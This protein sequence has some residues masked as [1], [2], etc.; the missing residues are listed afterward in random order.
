LDQ[1]DF[2]PAR[3]VGILNVDGGF[4]SA[5]DSSGN[6]LNREFLINLECPNNPRAYRSPTS[7]ADARSF[8]SRVIET[9]DCRYEIT[10]ES[11]LACPYQCVTSDAQ[12]PTLKTVCSGKGM[13]AA[14]PFAGF[15][16]CLCDDGV[17]G[18]DCGLYASGAG[19]AHDDTGFHVAIAI[20]SVFLVACLV[21]VVYLL[22]RHRQMASELLSAQL[23]RSTEDSIVRPHEAN[24]DEPHA[25]VNY[26]HDDDDNDS[27]DSDEDYHGDDHGHGHGHGHGHERRITPEMQESELTSVG[28]NIITN[29]AGINHKN[30]NTRAD[31]DADAA[32]DTDEDGHPTERIR[33]RLSGKSKRDGYMNA[34]LSD[35]D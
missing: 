15:V 14:D 1:I 31:A 30:S 34:D 17:T 28:N 35:S 32:K 22:M 12:D 10:I 29:E 26:G 6:P 8:D 11:S 9:A 24:Y 18:A 7:A 21:A 27:D 33:S 20:I 25:G 13:C 3:G 16:R 5:S 4:C 2:D 23:L 19:H